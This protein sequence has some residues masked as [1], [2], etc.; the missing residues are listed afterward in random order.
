MSTEQ[1]AQF[2]AHPFRPR[3]LTIGMRVTHIGGGQHAQD[4]LVCPRVV[5]TAKALA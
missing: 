4:G 5:I 2:S 3:V 1:L